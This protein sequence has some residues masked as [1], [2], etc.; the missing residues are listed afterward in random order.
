VINIFVPGLAFF[1]PLFISERLFLISLKR[2][3]KVEMEK[4]LGSPQRHTRGERRN[5]T[6]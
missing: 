2:I 5:I 6:K 3:M 1:F 4:N